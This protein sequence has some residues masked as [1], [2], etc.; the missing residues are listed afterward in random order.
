LQFGFNAGTASVDSL[1]QFLVGQLGWGKT[2]N[3]QHGPS[4]GVK[5]P[6][7]KSASGVARNFKWVALSPFHSLPWLGPLWLCH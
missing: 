3:V 6:D 5:K 7:G 1:Q 4:Q 2:S